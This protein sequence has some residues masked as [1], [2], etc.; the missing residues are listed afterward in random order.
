VFN[1]LR[2][3]QGT[4]ETE[5]DC[6]VAKRLVSKTHIR[7]A[8]VL[9]TAL[10]VATGVAVYAGATK[11][12]AAPAPT[13]TQVQAQINIL[14]G[15]VDKIGQ[16]YDSAAQEYAAAQARL[17]QVTKQAD[18]AQAEYTAASNALTSVAISSYENSNSTSILGLLT[19]G[20]PAAVLNQASLVLQVEGTHNAQAAQ[21]LVLA[22][23]LSSIR[24]Q[25]QRTEEGVAQLKSQLGTQKAT[26]TKLLTTQK[27]TLATL[28][29]AQQVTVQQHS[30]GGSTSSGTTTTTPTT[31]P[32]P[33]SGQAG[34]AVAY[35]Y[36]HLG[37]WYVWGAS[38][39]T[40]FDCSG[41]MMAA[42][43]SAGVTIPRTT[44]EQWAE[45]PHIPLADVQPGDLI[46]Y[47]GESHVAM[48]VGDGYIIDAPHTGATVER[49]PESTAW[50][51]DSADGAVRP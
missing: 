15:K 19:S 34:Q 39:P 42:W 32:V 16:Q 25:R 2:G 26:L 29:A 9:T 27:T 14:Q 37:D 33:T 38:G 28:T 44:Y 1:G 20:D 31:N 35:A 7:R 45:L 22:Q 51:A 8:A 43:Q 4:N 24:A 47:E 5:C 21:F 6:V 11:A 36:A 12:G 13:I 50:Y 48:Y 23:E 46:L 30:V 49:I 10:A 41:L 40:Y 17:T 18:R 3:N